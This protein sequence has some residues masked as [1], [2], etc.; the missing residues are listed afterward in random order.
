MNPIKGEIAETIVCGTYEKERPP[1]DVEL[2]RKTLTEMAISVDD[3][4]S[5]SGRGTTH[6]RVVVATLVAT[7]I[8]AANALVPPNSHRRRSLTSDSAC[9]AVDRCGIE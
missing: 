5:A 1:I 2:D 3:A 7:T 6:M 8:C 9:G 4:I